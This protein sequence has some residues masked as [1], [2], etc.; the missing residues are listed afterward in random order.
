VVAEIL[1]FAWSP[2]LRLA[3]S[4]LIV[5]GG[6]GAAVRWMVTGLEPSLAVLVVIQL[7]HALS[8]GATHLGTMGLLAHRVP[9]HSL[10]TAQ[11]TLTASIG[12]V[13]ATA[14][15]LCGRLFN[16]FGQSI[17]FGM[18]AMAAA[19]ALAMLVMR[20]EAEKRVTK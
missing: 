17:Y 18:A 11:G 2:R 20:Q 12:I 4:S 13:S 6:V 5:L 1:L 10:A 14:T 16:D 19:G 9:G 8:F 7:L 3:A 15:V